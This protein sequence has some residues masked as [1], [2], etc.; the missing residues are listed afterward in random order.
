M[1]HIASDC[2]AS[3]MAP[4]CLVRRELIADIQNRPNRI[5]GSVRAQLQRIEFTPGSLHELG[6]I[7]QN[8]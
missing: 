4:S 7:R 8:D 5:A 6:L 3:L 2:C 1:W